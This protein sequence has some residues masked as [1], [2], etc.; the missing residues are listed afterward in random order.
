MVGWRNVN[1]RL[2]GAQRLDPTHSTAPD[3][4]QP[5]IVDTKPE[6][7]TLAN[8]SKRLPL[9]IRSLPPHTAHHQFLP[10]LVP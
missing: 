6:W 4:C 2:E 1:T 5:I 3:H 9:Q 8:T 10:V 7:M